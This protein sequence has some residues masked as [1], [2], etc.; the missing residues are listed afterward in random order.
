MSAQSEGASI[1]F[2][3][4]NL[5]ELIA[6]L[7]ARDSVI[8]LLSGADAALVPAIRAISESGGLAMAQDPE[9]CFDPAAAVAL[10]RLG[11]QTYPALGL[12][13]QVAAR[14]SL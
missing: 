9:S 8:V 5:L 6:A 2:R 12:A 10:K 1:R 7:P 4:G 3:S 13:R 14:W 11:G